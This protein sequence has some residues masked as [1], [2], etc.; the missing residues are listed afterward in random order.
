[1]FYLLARR[2][3]RPAPAVI[4]ACLFATSSF[5]IHF[6][7]IGIGYN[8]TILLTLAVMYGF[9][10][11]IQDQDARWLSFA[12]FLSA[13]GFLSYQASKILAPLIVLS[14]GM[15]WMTRSLSWRGFLKTLAAYFLAFWIGIAPMIGVYMTDFQAVIS[16]AMS[17]T[18]LSPEGEELFRRGHPPDLSNTQLIGIQLERSLLAPISFHDNSPY[19][20]NLDNGGMLDAFPAI[21]FA[22]GV[23]LLLGTIFHPVS[24]LLIFWIACIL[25]AGGALTDHAP[26]YQR[27][28][29]LPPFLFIAAAPILNG[30]LIRLSRLFAWMPPTRLHVTTSVLIVL[31]I[32]SMHRYF[33]Q[34]MSKPQRLDEWTRVARYLHDAGPTQYTYFLGPP[35][36]YFRYGT[37]RFLAPDAKG[38]DVL[39]PEPF[40]QNRIVRRGPTCFLLIRSNRQYIDELRR[41]YPGGREENHFNQDEGAPFTTYVVNF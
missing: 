19:L 41:L 20:S 23:I 8:Q 18:L 33:H 38:E 10:R 16:R 31:L 35:H 6:S 40:V 29:G 12:G 32:F 34:I 22:A 28:V 5:L 37:L 2:V 9:V 26:S 24:R 7:R 3:L 25:F 27:L 4:A 30:C 21:F 15:L 1:L 39:H 11:G 36:V 14:L 17:V 13:V